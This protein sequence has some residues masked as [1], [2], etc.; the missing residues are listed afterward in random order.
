MTLMKRCKCGIAAFVAFIIAVLVAYIN[1][2]TFGNW[3]VST[4]LAALI[5]AG[6]AGF[7]LRC[8]QKEDDLDE[9]IH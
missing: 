9:H 8:R 5:I 2:Y 1:G 6:A 7:C 3:A 4:W